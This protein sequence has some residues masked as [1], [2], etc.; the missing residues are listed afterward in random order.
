MSIYDY[1]QGLLTTTKIHLTL[2]DPEKIL[3]LST[4]INLLDK[5]GTDGFLVGGST[6]SSIDSTNTAIKI[7][8]QNTTKPVILF[9]G[10]LTGIS[11]LADAI[12]FMSL[13]NSTDKFWRSGVQE[14]GA[15]IIKEMGLEPIAL[16]YAIVAPG[17]KVGEVGKA[18]VLSCSEVDKAANIA[19]AC[20]YFGCKLMYLDCGSGSPNHVPL[21]M[22]HQVKKNISIPLIVGGG[23]TNSSIAKDIVDHG[24]DIIV[25][26]TIIEYECYDEI[27]S[28]ISAIKSCK[29]K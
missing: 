18:D 16:G 6:V 9:P 24:A 15:P 1:L 2:V 17:M 19:L 7:I 5:L 10:G 23:I 12:F 4:K 11:P 21:E 28:I 22:I 14:K 25:T 26:G 13:V 3:N 8:K 20:E 29:V 27:A